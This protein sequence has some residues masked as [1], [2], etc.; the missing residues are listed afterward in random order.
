MA[1]SA[2]QNSGIPRGCALDKALR[3]LSSDWT[4]HILIVLS[5]NGP[6]RH[7]ALRHLVEGISSKVLTDR[8]RMLEAEG[9]VYRDYEPTVPPKVTYGLTDRG[10]RIDRT[11]R[12]LERVAAD[13]ITE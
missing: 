7:G 6:T 4:A 3:T 1:K 12:A 13:W 5:K 9:I 10:R 8:L 11:L 2:S